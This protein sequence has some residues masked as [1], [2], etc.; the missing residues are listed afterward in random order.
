[1]RKTLS[2]PIRLLFNREPQLQELRLH[3]EEPSRSNCPASNRSSQTAGCICLRKISCTE[4]LTDL[5]LPWATSSQTTTVAKP[6]KKLARSTISFVKPR[7]PLVFHLLV[8]TRKQVLWLTTL[9]ASLTLT[10]RTGISPS[11]SK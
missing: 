4:S 5:Q 7:S 1:M 3:L 6:P 11:F 10:S 2:R 8:A 9:S